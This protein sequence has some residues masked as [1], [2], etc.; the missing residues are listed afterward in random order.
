MI[1]NKRRANRKKKDSISR[2]EGITVITNA[3]GKLG[4]KYTHC[5]IQTCT[6]C[7]VRKRDCTREKKNYTFKSKSDFISFKIH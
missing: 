2:M 1:Y 3:Q 7:R 6:C 5:Y 4:I